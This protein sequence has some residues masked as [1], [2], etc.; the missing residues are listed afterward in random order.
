MM[1]PPSSVASR[2]ARAFPVPAVVAGLALLHQ[3]K[4]TIKSS[5]SRAVDANVKSQHLRRVRIEA[6]GACV[7]VACSCTPRA[8][9]VAA[10]KHLWAAFLAVDREGALPSIRGE[11]TAL[12]LT[13]LDADLGDAEP[14]EKAEKP[15]D[16]EK[17]P[18]KSAKS[19]PAVEAAKRGT[20]RST[21]RH[22]S[23]A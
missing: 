11:T 10:C 2:V 7:A 5:T 21:R 22:A 18:A 1:K 6:R 15:K 19:R 4:V 8:V 12:E 23:K 20:G 14:V 13:A 9:G 3:Q 16:K 17:K